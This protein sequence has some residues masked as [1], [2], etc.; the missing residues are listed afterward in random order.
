MV[1]EMVVVTEG[2][3][4]GCCRQKEVDEGGLSKNCY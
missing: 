3:G 4:G 2:S 1:M